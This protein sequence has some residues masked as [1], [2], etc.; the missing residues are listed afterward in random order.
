MANY[1]AQINILVAGQRNIQ[2]LANQLNAIED[3][4]G[5]IER[6][7]RSATGALQRA[8]IRL[9]ITGTQQ[10]RGEGG[11]FARDPDRGARLAAFADQRRAR[12]E[13]Q[14]S[15]I[16][17]ARSR[18]EALSTRNQIE[19]NERLISQT[20]RRIAIEQ[21]LNSAVRLF[22]TR[23]EKFRRGGGGSGAGLNRRFREE[24][25]ALRQEASSIVAAFDA[26]G[27]ASSRNLRLINSLATGLGRVVERQNELNRI[28]ALA[29]KGFEAG[30]RLQ[31]RVDVVAERGVV[32][33]RRISNL[34]QRAESV[35]AAAIS[36]NQQEY[37]EALRRASAAVSR[38][39]RES[40]KLADN[41]IKNAPRSPILGGVNFPGSP[42]AIA[43]QQNAQ[44]IALR[45]AQR[46]FPAS[47]IMGTATMAGSPKFLAA[48][49]RARSAAERALRAQE[50]SAKAAENAASREADKILKESQKGYPSSPIMG[51]ATMAGS[52]KAIAAQEQNRIAAERRAATQRRA[53]ERA[54]KVKQQIAIAAERAADRALSE[55]QKGFPSSPILGAPTMV[56]SPKWLVA[57]N[58]AKA[59]AEKAAKAQEIAARV[60]ESA[61]D[62]ALREAQK[63]YPSSPILGTTTMVGSPRFIAA[64]A[65]ASKS[66]ATSGFPSSPIRGGINMPGSPIFNETPFL[67]RS[68]GKRGGAAISEGLVGGAF[69]LLF[70]QGLGASVGGGLGG[71]V[72]GFAG[73]GLGFGLSLVGTALGTA[74]DTAV[75]SAKELGAALR[76][77]VENFDKLVESSFFSSRALE[78][79]IKKTIEYGDAASASAM[80]QEEA[81]RKFGVNGVKNLA[82]LESESDKLNRAWAELGQSIQ[83]LIAGPL[84]SLLRAIAKPIEKSVA[85]SRAQNVASQLNATQQ[86]QF[87]QELVSAIPDRRGGLPG[88]I[89]SAISLFGNLE[90]E[91]LK[92]ITEKWEPILLKGKIKIDQKQIDESTLN[93]LQKQLEGIDIAKGITDQIRSAA[94]EQQDLD[95]Q[96]AD[97]VRSYEEG[98]ANIRKQVEDEIARRRFS[99]LEKENQ[100]L[101]LQGQNR[102]KQLQNANQIIIARAGAGQRPEVEDA[103]K[104]AASIVAQF[105]EERV[106]AE[107]EA[108][109]IKR[110]AALDARKFDFEAAT[111]KANIEK[112]VS[113]LNIETARQVAQ[114]NEQVRRR[115]EETDRK[116]FEI[117]KQIAQIG[118][119]KF[120]GEVSANIENIKKQ[121]EIAK[122]GGLGE[123]SPG[124]IAGRN[125]IASY[126]A[127]INEYNKTISEIEK[128]RAPAPL[129]G[130]GAVG[131]GSVPTTQIS[132][133][134]SEEKGKI[135]AITEELTKATRL[136]AEQSI[137]TFKNKLIDLSK[138]FN[139][140]ITAIATAMDDENQKNIRYTQ[141]LSQGVKGVTAEKII[142]IEQE[143][144]LAK[145]KYNSA[146]AE[147]EIQKNAE[148]VNAGTRAV[149]EGQIVKYQNLRDALDGATAQ[150]AQRA[151]ESSRGEEVRGFINSSIESLNNLETV[152]IRVSQSIGNAV[153]GAMNEGINGLIDG[154]MTA[155]EVFANFLKN[156]S[157]I[158]MQ[159]ATK[160][161][162][163]YIAIGLA[164]QFAGLLGGGSATKGVETN[165]QFMDRAFSTGA[166]N[167][168]PSIGGYANGGM[169]SSNG[170]VPFAMGGAFTNSIVTAPTLFKFA[171][172][173][174][175]SAGV[176]GEAGPEAVMPLTRGR[177]GKLGVQASGGGDIN[178]TVNVDASGSK[179]QGDDAQANQLGRIVSAAVQAEIIKQKR[180]GGVLA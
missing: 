26:A 48:Q 121:I 47:P 124:V 77:P 6:R 60:A 82:Y 12:V 15:R 164:R 14:L 25:E 54:A 19:G 118:L 23:Q 79:Q 107:E 161:I 84:G 37:S 148:G 13:Q 20:E 113:R 149:I 100:L 92:K 87:R 72:G 138:A 96:R 151:I 35:I 132:A 129:R 61:A 55:A 154:T 63:G 24:A 45:Q 160:M 59:A 131:G 171:N 70:G 30:R 133:L 27:G 57:Q 135:R 4:I 69:P 42:R 120:I 83:A 179:V 56:G 102:I 146:I 93:A 94:R 22:E 174:A 122:A 71:A 111:F 130:V 80:I 31:E 32:P 52:P 64:Q 137:I 159:E 167:N 180:P 169:F 140:P 145:A 97:L 99:I 142:Q 62:K 28:S 85:I 104:Q 119:R 33:A 29:S 89:Q 91:Q 74:L 101:D 2:N 17:I 115:N 67:Q 81:I 50:R 175:M 58:R 108:A 123:M 53:E 8:N 136:N 150:L 39:E 10:P 51:T 155:Q 34:K 144:E 163:T 176:M 109:K 178:V 68:F 90:P 95:K 116:R 158:L 127:Q 126:Q 73:G 65:R 147:L 18:A 112:E 40:K 166:F 162:A 11:R 114:I 36:G 110:D 156:V 125:Q 173:G 44:E 168:V 139:A 88:N 1:D 41:I 98:I 165:A 46:G 141:L 153:G 105:T 43:A 177:D 78:D 75:Q 16:S 172:G 103:A 21:R 38:I 134:V 143:R 86:K 106:S 128:M 49:K 117:E 152:A 170:I 76:K 7:W 66:S 9:G 3:S 157:Q 5:Q